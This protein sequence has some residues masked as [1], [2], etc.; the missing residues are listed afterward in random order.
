MHELSVCSAIV[1][2]T[3]RHALGRRVSTVHLR[4]GALRQVVPESL[5]FYFGVVSRDTI[6]EGA[7]LDI[8]LIAALMRCSQCGREWDPAPEPI[9]T[10]DPEI[11]LPSFRC[12]DCD[13]AGAEVIAGDE[14]LIDSID[15]E[16]QGPAMA[17][18]VAS[19]G[20]D[21]RHRPKAS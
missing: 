20:R 12:P 5:D 4:V 18:A 17:E 7:D 10:G 21:P 2:T 3:I 6:C 14:L 8:E 19:N 1:D 16:N 15:V 9:H 13:A 11:N